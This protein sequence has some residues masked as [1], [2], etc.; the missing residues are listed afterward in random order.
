MDLKVRLHKESHQ[1]KW[2]CGIGIVL[3]LIVLTLRSLWGLDQDGGVGGY[4]S[5]QANSFSVQGTKYKDQGIEG[6][7]SIPVS[8]PSEVFHRS[9]DSLSHTDVSEEEDSLWEQEGISPYPRELSMS[10][11]ANMNLI[12]SGFEVVRVLLENEW[13]TKYQIRYTSNGVSISGVFLMPKKVHNPPVILLNHGYFPEAEYTLGR[14]LKREQDF[15]ARSGYA[16]LHSDYRGHAFSDENPDKRQLYDSSL[17]YAMDVVNALDALKKSSFALQINVESVVML[18][19]SMGG[20]IALDI[21][22]AY[23]DFADAVVLYAPSNGDAWKNFDRWKNE[24]FSEDFVKHTLDTYGTYAGNPVQWEKLSSSTYLSNIQTPLWVFH[25]E[26]DDIVPVQWSDDLVRNLEALGKDIVYTIYPLEDHQF[27][28]NYW[29]F[30]WEA[31]RFFDEKLK[32]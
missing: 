14:G 22:T 3:V 24:D 2:I 4:N 17:G 30:V 21:I 5:L 27:E 28:Q 8:V 20:E 15:F 19:H 26:K 6:N 25:G 10:G 1:F 29:D 11:F 23:P 13:Y 9:V 18:G 32:K 31:R 16:V 12:G 7:T